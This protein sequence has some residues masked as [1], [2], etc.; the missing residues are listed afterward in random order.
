M[1]TAF[2]RGGTQIESLYIVGG[3]TYYLVGSGGGGAWGL[4][5]ASK[6]EVPSTPHSISLLSF[7]IGHYLRLAL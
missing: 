1:S 5:D 3:E 6:N 2:V 7:L 4:Y